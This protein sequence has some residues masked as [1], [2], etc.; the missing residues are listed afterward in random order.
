VHDVTAEH[1]AEERLRRESLHDP[2]TNLPN[3]ALFCDLLGRAIARRGRDPEKR[4]AVLHVDCDRFK[5][6]NDALGHAAGDELL[7]QAAARIRATVRP[8]DVVARLTGDEF[9]VLLEDIPQAGEA[10][11]VANRLQDAFVL[12]IRLFEHDVVLSVSTGMVVSAA[13]RATAEDYLRDAGVATHRAKVAGRA[14][15]ILFIEEMR[16]GAR[17]QMSLEHDLRGAV[18]RGEIVVRYQPVWDTATRRLAG[19]EALVRWGHPTRGALSPSEFIPI[20]EE[21]GLIVPLGR[22]ALQEAC[23]Q[24]QQWDRVVGHEQPLWMSVN[25]AAKQLADST[26]QVTVEEALRE[27]G[28]SAD[29]LK[30]EVTENT[31]LSD[32]HTARA[33]LEGLRSIGVR[34]MMDDFGTGHASLTY[35]HRLPV[36][37]IKIDRYFVGRMHHS[38]ECLE[39]VRSIVALAKSLSME[40]VG[41]GV[42][43]PRQLEQLAGLG[44]QYV[45][46]FLLGRPLSALEAS[47][48][49]HQSTESL[50]ADEAFDPRDH[51]FDGIE[52]ALTLDEGSS[53]E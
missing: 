41:E 42:D 20:A 47:D 44:C 8:G 33:T 21:S 11:I 28:I 14:R 6:I 48:L 25:L 40:T 37:A 52:S 4:F 17:L 24:L 27:S 30:L 12:P 5:M 46:G 2:L 51:G 15:T 36:S 50:R 23:R 1:A 7:R 53:P 22:W 31:I 26:L 16:E 29:R 35:L 13:G 3:R 10:E 32:E 34:L 49:V 38:P 45:Q 19:F 43:D 39:I 9:V 18:E